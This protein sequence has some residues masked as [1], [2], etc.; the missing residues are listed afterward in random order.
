MDTAHRLARITLLALLIFGALSA[1]LGAVLGVAANGAGVPLQ[2]LEGTPFSSYVIPGLI[3]GVIVGGTQAVAAIAEL[4]R[5]PRAA[6]AAT[7]A[8]SGMVIWIFVE[9][10]ITGYFWLQ[11][12][13][14]AL[15]LGELLLVLVLLGVLHPA[16]RPPHSEVA[17]PQSA[18]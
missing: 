6:L 15:G 13:Y 10:A 17:V 7:I 4:R 11:G 8:G 9:L 3:L 5:H 14:F 12:L 18:P 16:P 2:Y 1:A